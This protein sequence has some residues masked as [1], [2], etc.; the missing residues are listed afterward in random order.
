MTVLRF[1]LARFDFLVGGVARTDALPTQICEVLA[2]T[3]PLPPF[4]HLPPQ[5]VEGNAEEP[6]AGGSTENPS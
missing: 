3:R 4:G 5:A 1:A 6:W 2:A